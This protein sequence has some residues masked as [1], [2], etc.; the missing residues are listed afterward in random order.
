MSEPAGRTPAQGVRRVLFTAHTGRRDI[1]EL[2][3]TSAARLIAVSVSST[4]SGSVSARKPTRPRFTPI[5][6]ASV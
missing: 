2:A 6:A 1:V 4:A 5:R 3:R